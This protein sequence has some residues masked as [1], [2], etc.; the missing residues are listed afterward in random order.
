MTEA[1]VRVLK[2]AGDLG[3]TLEEAMHRVSILIERPWPRGV[4]FG[5][6]AYHLGGVYDP[7]NARWRYQEAE[8]LEEA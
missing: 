1:V 2:D 4:F 5:Q 6:Q 3:L 8:S 7:D